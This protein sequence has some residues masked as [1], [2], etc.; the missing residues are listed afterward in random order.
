MI[1]PPN[2]LLICDNYSEE[3]L[4]GIKKHISFENL[5]AD[6][7]KILRRGDMLELRTNREITL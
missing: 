7:V 1:Y 4:A 5:T 6:D 2:T 3:N